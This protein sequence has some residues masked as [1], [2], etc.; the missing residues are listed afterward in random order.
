VLEIFHPIN[1]NNEN[2]IGERFP[3]L[4]RVRVE[5]GTQRRRSGV[6]G[7]EVTRDERSEKKS[8]RVSIGG[9][10]NEA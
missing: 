6:M 8:N 3:S 9:E 4:D 10:C 7:D 5:G 2:D 1:P